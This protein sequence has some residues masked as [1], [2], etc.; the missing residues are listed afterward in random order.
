[1]R[2]ASADTVQLIAG[3]LTHMKQIVGDGA[4]YAMLHYGAMEEGKRFGGGY[5]ANDLPQV[6]ERIDSVLLQRSEVLA[7]DGAT[8]R[9]RVFQSPLLATGQ[10][11]VQ[12]V[13]LGLLEGALSASRQGRYKGALVPTADKG[14][15]V[16]ELKR[17]A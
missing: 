8:V 2:E 5:G 1:M 14:E 12:G 9:V 16:V 6:L 13:I 15:L 17:D 7:D 4:S 11:S 3:L 10:R